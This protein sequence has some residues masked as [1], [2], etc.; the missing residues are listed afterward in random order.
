[1]DIVVED[2][3][4]LPTANAYISA[5]EADDILSVNIHSLWP[6]ITDDTVKE[7][8][9]MWATRLL[10]EKVRW[11]G[12]KTHKTSGL[13]WPRQGT[14]DRECIAIDDNLVPKQVKV[15]T[16][17]LADHLLAGDPELVNTSANLSKLQVDVIMLQFDTEK[18]VRKYPSEIATVLAALGYVSMSGGPKYIIR[19]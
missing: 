16:A 6:T 8:L 5:E 10:D 15:A 2:G 13:A 7:N 9:I 17:L 19:H 1:M 3:T 12:T 11:F 18:R 4:G 14:V